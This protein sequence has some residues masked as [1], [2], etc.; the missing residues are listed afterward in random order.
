METTEERTFSINREQGQTYLSYAEARKV[1]QNRTDKMPAELLGKSG[2]E[3]ADCSGNLTAA[4]NM[5][6]AEDLTDAGNL[7]A[8]EDLMDAEKTE[9]SIEDIEKMSIDD[10][11]A[12]SSDRSI[13]VP[14]DLSEKIENF[15]IASALAS[16]NGT[17]ITRK[18]DKTASGPAT[19]L[20]NVLSN[21][22]DEK[23][24]AADDV[25]SKLSSGRGT[26]INW[27][28]LAWIPAVA[29]SVAAVAIAISIRT[30]SLSRPP[31][32]SF[33]TPEEAYAQVELAFAMIS[34]KTSKAVY[35]SDAAFPEM[36]KT[37]KILE[38]MNR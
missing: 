5:T 33:T 4:G 31:K 1:A 22:S 36:N 17:K 8:A 25:Q 37:S 7:T 26:K 2:A 23:E 18:I 9:K 28:R 38:T 20:S 30:Y 24:Q 6:D 32:D 21:D 14:E 27:K 15:I 12:L 13:P 34:D 16:E 3:S 10:L 29:A 19:E 35:M 11:E